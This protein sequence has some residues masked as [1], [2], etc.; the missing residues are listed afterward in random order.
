[1][2]IQSHERSLAS[3]FFSDENDLLGQEIIKDETMYQIAKKAISA[4]KSDEVFAK[5]VSI[6]STLFET[7]SFTN[8][9]FQEL[10]NLVSVTSEHS[11]SQ[12]KTL[13]QLI[14]DCFHQESPNRKVSILP[15]YT[16]DSK[17]NHTTILPSGVVVSHVKKGCVWIEETKK[18]K[19]YPATI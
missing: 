18:Q 16:S 13:K 5:Y 17:R 11:N 7:E 14:Y 9:T 8:V 2:T 19:L 3:I 12:L 1:M 10:F 15:P 6:N 4:G